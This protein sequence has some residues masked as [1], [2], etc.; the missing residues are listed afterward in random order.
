MTTNKDLK[1]N[2]EMMK[3][4]KGVIVKKDLDP[5]NLIIKDNAELKELLSKQFADLTD[6]EKKKLP[7]AKVRITNKYN[8]FTKKNQRYI[9]IIFTEGVYFERPLESATGEETLLKLKYPKLFEKPKKKED[10]V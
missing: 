6:E 3:K 7:T 2:D 1:N 9:R 10:I 8:S 5:I 4:E